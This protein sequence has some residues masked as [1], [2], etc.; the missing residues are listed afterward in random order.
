MHSSP[1]LSLWTSSSVLEVNKES[2]YPAHKP[3]RRALHVR[4][5]ADQGAHLREAALRLGIS[6]DEMEA[7]VERGTVKSLVA[8]WTVMVLT[9]EVA[10]LQL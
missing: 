6:T 9:S 10:R 7:M 4:S 5:E 3:T 2:Q 1:C 8:G